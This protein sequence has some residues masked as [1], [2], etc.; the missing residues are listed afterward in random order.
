MVG[1]SWRFWLGRGIGRIDYVIYQIVHMI[2]DSVL[3]AT[4]VLKKASL[5]LQILDWL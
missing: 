5:T 4:K 3:P 2:Q 1:R